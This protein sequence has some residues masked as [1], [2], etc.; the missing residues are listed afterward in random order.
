MHQKIEE[1]YVIKFYAKLNKSLGVTVDMLK[2]RVGDV[3]D[4]HKHSCTRSS[5]MAEIQS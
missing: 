2:K 3:E 4:C 1:S 5:K